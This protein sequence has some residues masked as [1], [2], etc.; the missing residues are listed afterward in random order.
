MGVA[1]VTEAHLSVATKGGSVDLGNIR[2]INAD[3]HTGGGALQVR[4]FKLRAGVTRC[5]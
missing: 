4:Y 3:V 5:E 1:K 2:A